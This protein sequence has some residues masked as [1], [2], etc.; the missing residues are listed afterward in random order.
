MHSANE[1][2]TFSQNTPPSNTL[3]L[4]PHL[5]TPAQPS[6]PSPSLSLPPLPL[7]MPFPSLPLSRTQHRSPAS[8][9]SFTSWFGYQPHSRNA[10]GVWARVSQFKFCYM[11]F[12]YSPIFLPATLLVYHIPPRQRISRQRCAQC[13]KHTTIEYTPSLA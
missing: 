12:L 1:R 8:C 10:S 6:P 5:S 9:R 13:K 2:L 3:L 7:L 4:D 11:I